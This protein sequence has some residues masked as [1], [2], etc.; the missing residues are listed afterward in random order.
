MRM[1]EPQGLR[2]SPTLDSSSFSFKP[3]CTF[4]ELSNFLAASSAVHVSTSKK[5]QNDKGQHILDVCTPNAHVFFKQE[6]LSVRL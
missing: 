6:L 2:N 3:A 4:A 1:N 5:S